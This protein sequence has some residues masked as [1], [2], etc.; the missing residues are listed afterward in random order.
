[1]TARRGGAGMIVACVPVPRSA[2]PGN[3]YRNY[4]RFA[5]PAVRVPV[6]HTRHTIG[7]PAA[8]AR[9]ASPPR[10]E[11]PEWPRH[12][13]TGPRGRAR[14]RRGS[15][16]GCGARCR[17]GRAD[18]PGTR[19]R[20]IPDPYRSVG[21]RSVLSKIANIVVVSNRSLR[22]HFH[23]EITYYQHAAASRAR[24]RDATSNVAN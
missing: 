16:D 5:Y 13:G 2:I 21:E 10:R 3:D 14:R 15:D 4:P 8:T 20:A 7:A 11:A 9:Q 17:W 24:V 12:R 23:T 1:M 19:R 6:P 22:N 18:D